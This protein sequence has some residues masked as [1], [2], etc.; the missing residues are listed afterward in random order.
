MTEATVIVGYETGKGKRQGTLGKFIMQD[1][2]GICSSAVHR[3]K[4]M[5]TRILQVLARNVY[6][7]I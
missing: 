6:M 5:T 7:T 3:A 1:D 2:E 4:D